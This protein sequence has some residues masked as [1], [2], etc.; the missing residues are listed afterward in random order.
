MTAYNRRRKQRI[1]RQAGYG[2]IH[3]E[4]YFNFGIAASEFNQQIIM[5]I[6]VDSHTQNAASH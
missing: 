5:R 4:I 1:N 6:R 2:V 3:S